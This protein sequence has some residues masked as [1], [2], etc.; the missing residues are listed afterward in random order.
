MQIPDDWQPDS[1]HLKD[2]IILVTGAGAGIGAAV[3]RA[4]A[5]RGATVVLLDRIVREL[6]QVYDAI[7]SAGGPQA[8]IY[9]MNFEGASEKDYLDLAATIEQEFGRLDGLLH[10]A[11]LLGALI[12]IAHFEA[13]LWY[14][15]LQVNLNGPFLLT[16]ACLPLLMNSD[17]GAILFSSDRVGRQGKAY[18]GA[19][20]I[21]KAAA[22]NFMQVLA[23]ELETNTRVRVNSLDPGPVAT[24]LRALAY[25]AEDPAR[26]AAPE[27]VVRP[28]LYLLGPDSKGVTGAQFE[29]Q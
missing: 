13:E 17:D 7:E 14:R 22:E 29:A 19:Y 21:S 20:G 6:E 5:R 27:A 1:G 4:C 23:D 12:P 25:P 18:W 11:A 8:A 28:F 10:N 15:V 24:A 9:P 2:R 16:R 26:L 3:A